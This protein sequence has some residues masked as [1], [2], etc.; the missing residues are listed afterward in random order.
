M[1]ETELEQKLWDRIATAS[2]STWAY[3]IGM[4][5]PGDVACTKVGKANAPEERL[6]SLQTSNPGELSLWAVFPGGH[7]TEREIQR[8]ASERFGPPVRGEWWDVET[9]AFA[10][11]LG[12]E[13]L[14]W[15]WREKHYLLPLSVVP[16]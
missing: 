2:Q 9:Y 15:D 10:D 1:R 14:L 13:D 4:D 11:A 16:A 3:I 7:C 8:A 5:G 6:A 12:I